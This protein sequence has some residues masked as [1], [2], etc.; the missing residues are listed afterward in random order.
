MILKDKTKQIVAATVMR[1]GKGI[2]AR[3]HKFFLSNSIDDTEHVPRIRRMVECIELEL[4]ELGLNTNEAKNLAHELREYAKS[5]FME[6]WMQ[7]L[8]E[9]ENQHEV[10]EEG[11][12][13]F[14][15]IYVSYN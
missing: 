13:E 8:D 14:D 3:E 4:M 10:W 5:L 15:S 12:N 11:S 9:F 1:V 2:L 6:S 7:N